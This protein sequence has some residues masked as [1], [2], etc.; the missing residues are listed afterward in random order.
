MAHWGWD[1][2]AVDMQHSVQDYST[3]VQCFQ[4]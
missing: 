3:M 4:Q 1:S 2:V